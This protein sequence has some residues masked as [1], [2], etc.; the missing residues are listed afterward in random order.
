MASVTGDTVFRSKVKGQGRPT[1]L[2]SGTECTTKTDECMVVASS[3]LVAVTPTE[4]CF[5]CKTILSGTHILMT[6]SGGDQC[7][8]RHARIWHFG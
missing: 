1:L 4:Q 5:F 3:Y 7:K 6:S 2:K 8:S